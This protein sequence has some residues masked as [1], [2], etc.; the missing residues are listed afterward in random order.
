MPGM[1][2]LNLNIQYGLNNMPKSNNKV[3]TRNSNEYKFDK[4]NYKNNPNSE[5][6]FKKR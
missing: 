6:L 5:N 4:N 3:L 1:N 2:Q